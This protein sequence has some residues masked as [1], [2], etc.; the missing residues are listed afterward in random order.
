[1]HFDDVSINASTI[2]GSISNSNGDF[3]FTGIYLNVRPN[4]NLAFRVMRAA[5]KPRGKVLNKF[6][7]LHV[8]GVNEAF[9]NAVQARAEFVGF[10]GQVPP[11]QAPSADDIKKVELTKNYS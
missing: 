9:N 3:G 11:L 4:S 10:T 2:L 6:F 1:L 8:H 5:E 7:S